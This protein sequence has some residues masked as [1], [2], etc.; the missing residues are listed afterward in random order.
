MRKLITLL[1]GVLFLTGCIATP[2]VSSNAKPNAVLCASLLEQAHG[3][4]FSAT[5]AG[6]NSQFGDEPF[7]FVAYSDAEPDLWFNVSVEDNA[8][9]QDEYCFR[10]ACHAAELIFNSELNTLGIDTASYAYI[11]STNAY[12]CTTDMNLDELCSAVVAN[13]KT[14]DIKSFAKLYT[15][16]P[17]GA[18]TESDLKQ[19]CED[20]ASKLPYLDSYTFE[21][22]FVPSNKLFI[23][24]EQV[25]HSY[26]FFNRGN[27]ANWCD[28]KD[29]AA[30]FTMTVEGTKS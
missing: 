11:D 14:P 8:L 6:N 20:V 15:V 17:E 10:K 18:L 23:C 24:K 19:L 16:I 26:T 4:K 28:M 7:F 3:E 13:C 9:V 29:L 12:L 1:L 21:I 5:L 2:A 27:I 22:F 30:S 25:A